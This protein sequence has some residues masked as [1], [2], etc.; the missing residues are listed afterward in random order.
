MADIGAA[1][2][3]A[4]AETV[5]RQAYG[6][7]LAI[8]VKHTADL[9]D[10]E[11]AL[12]GALAR[13]LESWPES[14]VPD[15]PDAWLI[16]TARRRLIDAARRAHTRQANEIEL[17]SRLEAQ[18]SNGADARLP[19]ER[20][21]LMLVC[22]HPGI[23]A[24]MHTPLMLQCVLGVDAARI[25]S[26]FLVKP[27][28]MGQR[29]ARAKARIKAAQLSFEIPEAEVLNARLTPVLDAIYAAYTAGWDALGD[30]GGAAQGL[31][32]EARF[33]AA[34]L[35]Q[36]C[37]DHGEALALA[38]LIEH[39]EARKPARRDNNRF[40]PLCEQ[41][42]A[43]WDGDL[44]DSAE[45]RLRQAMR[46]GSPGRY[47]LEAALQS[48]H[49]ERRL[50][51]RTNWRAAACLYDALVQLS[52][53]G[54]G[55]WVARA[56]AHGEAHGPEAALRQLAELKTSGQ[57]YQPFWAALGH[58]SAAA[59]DIEAARGAFERAAALSGDPAVR[60]HLLSRA[61]AL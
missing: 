61:E 23:D 9:A 3:R 6:R 2:A 26:A 54:F 36:L 4:A 53:A 29:L 30:E 46:L 40:I 25:A 28:T 34:L 37:P 20:L 14:G 45:A 17:M 22:A 44:I 38:S 49:A 59:G 18:T 43:L 41:D 5:A 32:G 10:A 7:L 1:G 8:L 35:A 58:W 27:A 15:N 11:D 13:A 50:T 16:S 24:A 19:D 60:R 12:G 33:L 47:G 21:G 55:A 57:E 52:T 56:S 51:G 48:V 39:C 42:T 31:T